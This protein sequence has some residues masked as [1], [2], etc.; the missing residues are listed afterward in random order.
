MRVV[1]H[2]SGGEDRDAVVSSDASEIFGEFRN[3]F[4]GNQVFALFGAEYAMGQEIGI[5]MGHAGNIAQWLRALSVTDVTKVPSLRDSDR[6]EL[7][8]RHFRAGLSHSVPSAL[9]DIRRLGSATRSGSLTNKKAP[10]FRAGLLI[11]P[12]AND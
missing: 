9:L 7:L 4:G 2:A 6:C 11:L 10:L 3:Q 12:M 5:L 1:G 8:S